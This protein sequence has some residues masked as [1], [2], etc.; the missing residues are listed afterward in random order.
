[1]V[2]IQHFLTFTY[3]V[4]RKDLATARYSFKNKILLEVH[5]NCSFKFSNSCLYHPLTL[6]GQ[7]LRPIHARKIRPFYNQFSGLEAVIG[8]EITYVMLALGTSIKYTR[9]FIDFF[10]FFVFLLD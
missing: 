6:L 8:S 4:F 1:M 5:I 9:I 3:L 2:P 7:G 10:N